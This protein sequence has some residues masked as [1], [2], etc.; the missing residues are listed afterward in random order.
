MCASLKYILLHRHAFLEQHH[1]LL[2]PPNDSS[3]VKQLIFASLSLYSA[4]LSHQGVS[5][6]L[7]MIHIFVT[8]I[9]PWEVV[10]APKSFLEFTQI[11]RWPC[12]ALR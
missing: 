8:L 11:D 6:F 12:I 10:I 2:A 9:P 7:K 4:F 1:T 3:D 5:I